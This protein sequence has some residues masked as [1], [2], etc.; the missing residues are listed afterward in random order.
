MTFPPQIDFSKN[1]GRHIWSCS[2][3]A[4]WIRGNPKPLTAESQQFMEWEKSARTKKFRY[5]LAEDGL[6]LLQDLIEWPRYFPK[7]VYRYFRFRFVIKTH[8]LTSNLKRGVFHEFDTRMLHALFDELV[9]FVETEFAAETKLVGLPKSPNQGLAYLQWAKQLKY[10]D[11]WC[12]K[13]HPLLGKPT[14]QAIAAQ[15][16]FDLYQ[17]WKEK[18]PMREQEVELYEDQYNE[19]TEMLIRLVKLRRQIWT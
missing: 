16:I 4:D 3:F 15:E 6:N 10:D 8:A 17:W 1:I 7:K 2:K 9:N 14:P 13:D 5:W 19:D 12:S 18:R 11:E